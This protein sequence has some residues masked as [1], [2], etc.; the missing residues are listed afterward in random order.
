[1]ATNG[2]EIKELSGEKKENFPKKG[3]RRASRY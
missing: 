3:S 2:A 1:M